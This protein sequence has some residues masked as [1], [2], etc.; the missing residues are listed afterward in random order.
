[1]DDNGDRQVP[2]NFEASR[3]LQTDSEVLV[4]DSNLTQDLTLQDRWRL[5]LL[6]APSM[7]CRI[8][9]LLLPAATCL[10]AKQQIRCFFVI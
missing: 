5:L 6:F 2:I 9:K 3:L 8:I 4:T 1:M 10:T 7:N